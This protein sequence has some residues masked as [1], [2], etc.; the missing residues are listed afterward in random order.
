MYQVHQLL[1]RRGAVGNV[2]CY[3]IST[4]APS[5][6]RS[7]RTKQSAAVGQMPSKAALWP[8]AYAA[9][10]VIML[11]FKETQAVKFL[12]QRGIQ[13]SLVATQ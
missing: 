5:L 9:A 6:M 12:A 10:A 13:V 11:E 8:T 1:E 3:S 4:C 7:K 2:N